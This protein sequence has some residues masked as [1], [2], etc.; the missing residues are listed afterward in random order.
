[1]PFVKCEQRFKERSYAEFKSALADL[2][3]DT[4]APLQKQYK[5]LMDQKETLASL[6][7]KGEEAAR[8]I[9]HATLAEAKKKMGLPI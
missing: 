8:H 2:L 9:A 4:L 7:E 3:I 5:N 6:L 1:M